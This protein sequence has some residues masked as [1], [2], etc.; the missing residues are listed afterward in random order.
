MRDRAESRVRRRG[1]P[2]TSATL[3]E[4]ENVSRHEIEA[5]GRDPQ[6]GGEADPSM[7]SRDEP[8]PFQSLQAVLHDPAEPFA[9]SVTLGQRELI[10]RRRCSVERQEHTKGIATGEE[11]PDLEIDDQGIH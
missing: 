7:I 2:S 8:R 6:Y 10:Q 4:A 5:G 1:A 11:R 3:S 9:S